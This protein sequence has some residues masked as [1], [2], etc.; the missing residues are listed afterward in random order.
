MLVEINEKNIDKRLI[1]DIVKELKKGELIIFPTDTVY[2]IGCDLYNKKALQK[3]AAFKGIKL[4]KANFSLICSS[5][6]HLSEFVKHI[7]RPTF[8]LLNKSLPGPFTFILTANNEIPRLFDSNKKEV[9]I[10]IPDNHITRLIVDALGHPLAS[11][12]LHSDDD[13]QEYYIDPYAIYEQHD[14]D[15]AVIIDGGLGRLET[16][17]IVD[18]S[19]S[20]PEILRQGIGIIDL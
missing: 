7:D 15:V 6:S 3:L 5:L 4:N 13:I 20:E 19:G 10:R 1:E 2:A 12:S 17:T 8:K 14:R 11:T 18:C 9:G 16:S